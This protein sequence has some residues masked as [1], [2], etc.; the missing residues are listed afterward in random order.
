MKDFLLL[1][2]RKFLA[3]RFVP[4]QS[5]LIGYS[6]GPD[7]TALLHLFLANL[8]FFPLDLHLAHVDHGWRE[9][10][11]GEALQ[12]QAQAEQLGLPFYLKTLSKKD[13]LPGNL[14]EQGRNLRL[15]FFSELYTK[16]SF[17]ALALGHHADD[18]AE[19]VLKRVFEGASLFSL[20]GLTEEKQMEGM[21]VWRPLLRFPKKKLVEWLEQ[22]SLPFIQDPTNQSGE[23]LRGK[24]RGEMI[25][26]LSQT[27]GKEIASNLCKLGEESQQIRDYFSL[28]NQPIFSKIKQEA[29]GFCLDLNPF[30]PLPAIQIKYLVKELSNTIGWVIS[31]QI[32]EDAVKAI[33]LRDGGKKFIVRHCKLQIERGFI[34]FRKM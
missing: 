17:Q 10:S 21:T 25:P 6:G 24:I 28:L 23:N 14:E 19:V 29:T 20:G 16:Q 13:F 18:Q 8:R 34:Y 26:S 7:S 30:L 27:F 12:L 1:N 33:C 3:S 31:K 22:R 32:L 15:K 4:G 9:E 5:I 11:R 2:V